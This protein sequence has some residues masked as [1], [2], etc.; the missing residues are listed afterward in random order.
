MA[1]ADLGRPPTPKIPP[2][3]PPFPVSVIYSEQT[4]E[5]AGGAFGSLPG[6]TSLSH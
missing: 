6:R 1:R 4:A 2:D 3:T 5:S